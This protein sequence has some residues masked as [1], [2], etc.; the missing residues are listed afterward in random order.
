MGRTRVRQTGII[1]PDTHIP[2]HSQEAMNVVY[3]A[4]KLVKP[5]LV[6]H[7][8]DVGEWDA[9]SSWKYAKKKRPPLEQLVRN[10]KQD[11]LVV[12][13][14]LD[15][16]DHVCRNAGVKEKI[17]LGG[18]HE[19]WLD[20]FV[21]DNDEDRDFLDRFTP[22]NIMKLQERGWEWVNHGEYLTIGELTF[23]HGGHCGTQHHARQHLVNLGVNVVYG[24]Q[25][26]VQRASLS[27]LNGVHA[28]FCIGCLKSCQGENNKWLRGRKVN[29]S[30]AFA[31]V[32]W[33]S[34]GTFRVE[35]VD[36]T[37]G[38]TTLWGRELNG[39]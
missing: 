2:L 6:M 26:S 15:R 33:N 34:D 5:E 35:M 18:N 36:V 21:N 29:W 30:H 1:I 22:Q 39:N 16:L 9:V 12:N 4:I 31:I 28:A 25:H 10:L 3:K 23:Y 19:V 27:G 17:M 24:H 37:D 20:N 13:T 11:A 32:Y 38:R 14:E 8:G 7:L